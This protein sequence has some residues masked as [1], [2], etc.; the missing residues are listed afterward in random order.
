[1]EHDQNALEWLFRTLDRM[2]HNCM[3][4]EFDKRGLSEASHP[5]ILFVLKH[6]I[7]DT[8]ASQKEIADLI[9]ISPVTVA[10]SIKRMERSGLIRKVADPND[11]RRNLITITE[12]GLKLTTEC[13]KAI[14]DIDVGM[15]KGFSSEEC[16]SLKTFYIKMIH[17]M[18]SMG[19]QIPAKLKK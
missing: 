7:E 4:A 2:H 17:N 16:R 12:K 10:I 5:A 18:E 15:F 13:E 3:K 6:E 19:V 8:S 11:L 1:M 9:G 14:D